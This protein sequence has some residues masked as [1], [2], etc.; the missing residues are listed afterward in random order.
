MIE[1]HKSNCR[2]S[3]MTEI[4]VKRSSVIS[5]FIVPWICGLGC[6][7]PE[8]AKK[9]IKYGKT[10][11][12]D[13]YE[14]NQEDIIVNGE[15]HA[16]HKFMEKLFNENN[17][18]YVLTQIVGDNVY[19]PW[20]CLSGIYQIEIN[21]RMG[22]VALPNGVTKNNDCIVVVDDY[23]T[24]FYRDDQ[25]EEV[26]IKLL[27]TMSVW[28]AKRGIYI[29]TKMKRNICI[30]FDNSKWEEILRKIKLWAEY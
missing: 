2:I 7:T 5:S 3:I 28:K 19:K 6:K 1:P 21:E 13:Y 17:I 16:Y 15:D 4:F 18:D 10:L 29:I 14:L 11:N 8:D 12:P 23:L 24:K 9:Y 30:E 22:L 20:D 26:K 25:E 27:S